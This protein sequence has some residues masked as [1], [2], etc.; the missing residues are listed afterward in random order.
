MTTI[1]HSFAVPFTQTRVAYIKN[2]A[3][4]AVAPMFIYY[5]TSFCNVAS[6]RGEDINICMHFRSVNLIILYIF[7]IHGVTRSFQQ[8]NK[9]VD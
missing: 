8:I 5:F 6:I 3:G 1:A 4:G 9:A 2:A 7:T